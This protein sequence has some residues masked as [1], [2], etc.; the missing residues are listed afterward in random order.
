MSYLFDIDALVTEHDRLLQKEADDRALVD[1][2]EF[3]DTEML[4]G[5][6]VE[7]ANNG[8][9]DGFAIFSITLD[10]PMICSDGV[11][12]SLFEYIAYLAGVPVGDKMERLTTK[13]KGMYVQC[14]YS[15]NTVTFH[16]FKCS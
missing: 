9:A 13:L 2:I 11:H 8:F 16:V 14:S 10:V 12:R 6:L 15:G 4:R 5:K 3:P 7:W 1:T